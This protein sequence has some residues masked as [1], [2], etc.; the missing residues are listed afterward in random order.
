[1]PTGGKSIPQTTAATRSMNLPQWTREKEWGQELG[2]APVIH[3]DARPGLV[4]LDK[5]QSH[6]LITIPV[7]PPQMNA[8]RLSRAIADRPPLH[9]HRAR[10]TL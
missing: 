1:M 9:A 7:P 3:M 6:I 5:L 4:S 10:S 2:A 8:P